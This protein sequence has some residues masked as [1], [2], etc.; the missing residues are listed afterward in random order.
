MLF[1]KFSF[2]FDFIIIIKN[3]LYIL[4]YYINL[5]IILESINF[6]KNNLK[7]IAPLKIVLCF[8]NNNYLVIINDS[9]NPSQ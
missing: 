3:F 4:I 9:I 7:T 5:Q 1:V 8:Y 6:E 2:L